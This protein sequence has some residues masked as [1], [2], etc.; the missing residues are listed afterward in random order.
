MLKTFS[1]LEINVSKQYSY[2]YAERRKGAVKGQASLSSPA[3]L[4]SGAG[5]HH[6]AEASNNERFKSNVRTTF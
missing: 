5:E 4:Q 2:I 1:P 6:M 3:I